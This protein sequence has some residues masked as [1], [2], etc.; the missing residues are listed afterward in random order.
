MKQ[1]MLKL[2]SVTTALHIAACSHGQRPARVPK[3]PPPPSACEL[4]DADACNTLGLQLARPPWPRL[5]KAVQ[6]YRRGCDLGS[7]AACANLANMFEVGAVTGSADLPRAHMFYGRSCRMDFHPACDEQERLRL[8]LE[9][10]HI[11]QLR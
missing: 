9:R 2:V 6:L 4:G 7:A 1:R 3:P 10:L 11:I 8:Q 5:G